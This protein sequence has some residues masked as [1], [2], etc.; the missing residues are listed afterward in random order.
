MYTF[1]L[2]YQE[3]IWKSEAAR[4]TFVKGTFSQNLMKKS[5]L[6]IPQFFQILAM[7]LGRALQ[8]PEA[9]RA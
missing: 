1:T 5:F 9:K 7:K 3:T 8:L 4:G 6:K 2:T